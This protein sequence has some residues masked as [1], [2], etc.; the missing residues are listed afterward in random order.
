MEQ[1]NS[2]IDPDDGSKQIVDQEELKDIDQ[3]IAQEK[4]ALQPE[5][6]EEEKFGGDISSILIEPLDK[7]EQ[8]EII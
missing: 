4:Q 7:E 8:E 3:L 1:S 6:V 2:E 5:K